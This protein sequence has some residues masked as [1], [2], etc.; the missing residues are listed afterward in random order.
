MGRKL[1]LGVLPNSAGGAGAPPALF[2]NN[3]ALFRE[4]KVRFDVD[5]YIG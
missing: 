4:Q 3:R 2:G 5:G 1:A